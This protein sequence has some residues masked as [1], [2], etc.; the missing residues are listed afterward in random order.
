MQLTL[1]SRKTLA[2]SH[3]KHRQMLS[4]KSQLHSPIDIFM[5]QY[6]MR[7]MTVISNYS[8]CHPSD[9]SEFRARVKTIEG[10]KTIVFI[11]KTLT[12]AGY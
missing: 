6:V 1:V 10:S 4:Y 12:L 2:N 9:R 11:E 5:T 8:D 3:H 7:R